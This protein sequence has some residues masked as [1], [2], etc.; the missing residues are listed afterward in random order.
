VLELGCG[1]GAVTAELVRR[2]AG[3]VVALDVLREAVAAVDATRLRVAGDARCL[4]FRDG[5]VDLVFGQLVLT[6]IDDAARAASEIA[7]VLSPGGAVALLEA[8]HAGLMEDPDGAAL[9][10]VW[11]AALRRAG[12]DPAMG[13]RVPR[14]LAEAGLAV[15]A[16]L[17]DRAEPPDATRFALLE[18][19][20]LTDAERARVAAARA[21]E[22]A[23]ALPPTAHLPLWLVVGEKLA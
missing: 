19:L 23:L 12:A 10:E 1:W 2:A 20:P 15:T 18:E 17:A 21:A 13:R 3:P 14:L 6:W 9:R 8:D 7:R 5:A 4:P 11:I 22:A 16:R